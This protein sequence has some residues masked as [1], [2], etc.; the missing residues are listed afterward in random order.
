MINATTNDEGD[1]KRS[2]GDEHRVILD[3]VDLDNDDDD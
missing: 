2:V 3:N 1:V